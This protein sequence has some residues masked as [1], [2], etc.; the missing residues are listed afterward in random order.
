MNIASRFKQAFGYLIE[1]NFY[2]AVFVL[3]SAGLLSLSDRSVFVYNEA[4]YGALDNNLRIIMVYLALTEAVVV[5]YCL[6][7]KRFHFMMLVGF[8]LLLMI[9]SL[10]FYGEVN[11]VEIDSDFTDFFL[12]TGLSHL[13]YGVF[14]TDASWLTHLSR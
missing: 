8:F 11:T 4:L 12:Y 6:F 13:V 1:A 10:D 5:A 9:G 2:F 3:I 14:K 7:S